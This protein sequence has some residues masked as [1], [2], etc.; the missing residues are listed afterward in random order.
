[1]DLILLISE[2]TLEDEKLALAF[3]LRLKNESVLTGGADT[4]PEPGQK[5]SNNQNVE[6]IVR[7]KY[8]GV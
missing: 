8:I 5:W 4:S 3:S 6:E 7:F 1:M 2:S